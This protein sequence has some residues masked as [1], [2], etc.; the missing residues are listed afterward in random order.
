MKEQA[1]SEKI[2][3][4]WKFVVLIIVSII[5]AVALKWPMIKHEMMAPSNGHSRGVD[6]GAL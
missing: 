5:V 2:S 6:P 1:K 4:N 3:T